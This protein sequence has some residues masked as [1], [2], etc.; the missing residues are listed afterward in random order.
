MS[1]ITPLP[2]NAASGPATWSSA[3][4]STRVPPS[5]SVRVLTIVAPEPLPVAPA[6]DEALDARGRVGLLDADRPGVHGRERADL[7][8][9]LAVVGAVLVAGDG[10]AAHA[11]RD[12]LEVVE[13][14]PDGLDRRV[15]LEAELELHSRASSSWVSMSVALARCAGLPRAHA[16]AGEQLARARVALELADGVQHAAREHDRVAGRAVVDARGRRRSRPSCAERGG[17]HRGR[18]ERLVAERDR[19][20]RRR[21]ASAAR[22]ARSEKPWPCAQSSQMTTSAPPKSTRCADRVRVVAEHDDHARRARRSS[23]RPRAAAAACRAARRAAWSARRSAC[24]RPRRG[25]GPRR[26]RGPL[27]HQRPPA[28]PARRS[29]CRAAAGRRAASRPSSRASAA[30]S[31]GRRPAG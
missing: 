18:D 2:T 19:R 9:E 8:R 20:R 6:T 17:D 23:R 11:G 26:S 30:R 27:L 4:A 7:E 22:R 25:S 15:D 10:R 14:R 3:T 5:I 29:S 16:E 24:P 31:A 28:P 1:R 13:R 12:A 21:P